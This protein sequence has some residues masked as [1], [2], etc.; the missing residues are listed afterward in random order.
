[1]NTRTLVKSE[2]KGDGKSE[3]IL[4]VD[5]ARS[6]DTS[7]NQTSVAVIKIKRAKGG[8][9]TQLPLVNIINIS[10]ALNFNAQAVE[11]KRIKKLYNAKVVIVDTNGLGAGLL[12]KL[13]EDTTD[14]LTGESLGCWGTVNT[15][16]VPEMDEYEE[17]VYDLK[18]QS[19]NSEVIISFIDMV[20]SGKLQLLEKRQF[21]DIDMMDKDAH[22]QR[23]PFINTDFLI[24]EI[25]NLKLKQL[26]SGK[27]TVE[28]LIKKYNKD[29]YSALA[30]ALWY[31]KVFEDV[32]YQE[33]EDDIFDYLFM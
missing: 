33:N 19:A 2:L 7:N 28:R 1:M 22:L 24:E 30:Y 27:Y 20:E 5:V 10:N 6:E 9:I 18:P 29:R 15:D 14:P 26:P 32:A 13:L 12:D 21:N 8:R 11:V 31:I 17:V 25:A 4:G 16:Q 3:Y 23:L